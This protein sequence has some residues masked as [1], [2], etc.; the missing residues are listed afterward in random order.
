MIACTKKW[1]EIPFAHRSP[2]H[3]GHC[4]FIHGHNWVIEAEFTALTTDENGFV[5]DFG[6]LK[7]FWKEVVDEF[8]HALVLSECDPFMDKIGGLNGD[9][10]D[11]LLKLV[12]VDD[13]SCEGLAKHFHTMLSRYVRRATKGRVKVNWVRLY[14][15]QKNSAIYK[16]EN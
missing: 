14:E 4:R 12:I 1:Q 16:N 15:D 10:I 5:M 11:T 9:P 8:D 6:G 7:P 3:K 2:F 13:C